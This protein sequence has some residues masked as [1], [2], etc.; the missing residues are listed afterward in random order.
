MGVA[1]GW[2]RAKADARGVLMT[3]SYLTGTSI[4]G[5]HLKM[6]PSRAANFQARVK[7]EDPWAVKMTQLESM[8]AERLMTS[9]QSLEPT[10]ARRQFLKAV[11]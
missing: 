5:S 7:N 9:V 4:Q 10:L 8:F 6:R 11:F 2:Y 1:E 3:E